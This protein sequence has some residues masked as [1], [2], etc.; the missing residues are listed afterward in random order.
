MSPSVTVGWSFK[1]SG[2]FRDE[3]LKKHKGRSGASAFAPPPA[4]FHPRTW[5]FFC[6]QLS[7]IGLIGTVLRAACHDIF[8]FIAMQQTQHCFK[9]GFLVLLLA[10]PAWAGTIARPTPRDPLLDGGD[11]TACAAGVDYA[12]GADVTGHPVVPADVGARPVPVPDSIAVPLQG[13]RRGRSNPNTL[14]GDGAYAT[15]DGRKLEP[16][17]NPKPCR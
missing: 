8:G 15:L 5:P 4:V 16:L 10:T 9:A 13:G 7:F 6:G 1:R 3:A 11:T 2:D 12:A 14:G 17:L